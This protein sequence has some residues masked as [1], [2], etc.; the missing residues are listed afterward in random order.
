MPFNEYTALTFQKIRAGSGSCGV[1]IPCLTFTKTLQRR[2]EFSATPYLFVRS[3]GKYCRRRAT[4]APFAVRYL[5]NPVGGFNVCLMTH[6]CAHCIW[7]GAA[8]PQPDYSAKSIE[9]NA[10]IDPQGRDALLGCS[11]PVAGWCHVN[12]HST[13]TLCWIKRRRTE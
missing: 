10:S 8:E 1:E 2:H 5:R 9:G 7:T 13:L 11:T 12:V 6:C 3:H 4:G